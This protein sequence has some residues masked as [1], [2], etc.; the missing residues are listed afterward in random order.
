MNKSNVYCSVLI[1]FVSSAALVF[2]GFNNRRG[3]IQDDKVLEVL[4]LMFKDFTS[5]SEF[6]QIFCCGF[7]IG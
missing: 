2:W 3:A 4:K 6:L 1:T 7:Y 5:L